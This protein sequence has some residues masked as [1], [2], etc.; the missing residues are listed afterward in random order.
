MYDTKEII[1]NAFLA[2]IKEKSP[3]KVTII[4]ICKKANVSRETFYYHFVDKYDLFKWIYKDTLTK[5]IQSHA[6]ESSW[7][8]MIEKSINDAV[9][10]S[11]FF[12]KV[13]GKAAL[14]YSE[15]TFET[16]YEVYYA[17]LSKSRPGGKLPHQTEAEMYIYLKGGI[18]F[19][20]H[21]VK[22]HS[23]VSYA[24]ISRLIAGAM[25]ERLSRLWDDI[26]ENNKNK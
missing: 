12:E 19:F 3:D 8:A 17:E 22:T 24:E 23:N 9:E 20:K 16:L 14:E 10:Y 6:T 13:L 1:A 26:A 2:L 25:P 4:D 11:D 18:E 7:S 21:Y 15:I 5:R